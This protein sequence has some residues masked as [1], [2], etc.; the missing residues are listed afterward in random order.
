LNDLL[1]KDDYYI[2]KIA[3]EAR[4]IGGAGNIYAIEATFANQK[5]CTGF[6]FILA[7]VFPCEEGKLSSRR[8]PPFK[9]E[10]EDISRVIESKARELVIQS[11]E[12]YK[13]DCAG[14]T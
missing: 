11:R 5:D 13:K 3:W 2:T 6:S 10:I 14:E 8:R 7:G 12:N 9:N 4:E 1:D